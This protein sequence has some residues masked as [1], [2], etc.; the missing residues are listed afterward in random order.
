MKVFTSARWVVV[1]NSGIL[2]EEKN[3]ETIDSYEKIIRFNNYQ[4]QPEYTGEIT[5][6]WSTSFCP[7]IRYPKTPFQEAICPF[8]VHI[9]KYAKRYRINRNLV[10]RSSPRCIPESIF[11]ALKSHVGFPSTGLA[12][13][14]WMY[15]ELGEV[16]DIYGFSFFSGKHH[17]FDENAACIHNGRIE[18]L[19]YHKML[20]KEI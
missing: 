19:I 8:P 20:R 10:E 13:L 15:R 12:T 14:W 2:L 1:G 11:C 18:K 16:P 3:G 9:R 17:Y 6:V 5:T 4:I 7:D